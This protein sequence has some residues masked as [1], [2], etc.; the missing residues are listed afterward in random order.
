M[1]DI[2]HDKTLAALEQL[3]AEKT[4]RL[5]DKIAAGDVVSQTVTV[6]CTRDED[7]E[8]ACERALA[9]LPTLDSD[10]RPIHHDLSV[11]V[12]GV[13]R[14]PD[15]ARWV[16]LQT[17]ASSEGPAL[18]SEETAGSGEVSSPSSPSQPSYVKITV[19]NGSEDDPGQIAE[20]YYT[21]EDGQL[22]LRD[23]NDKHLTSRAL[24]NGENPATLAK[25]LLREREGQNDFQQPIH[26]PKLGFA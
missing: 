19:R 11:I 4:R 25:I 10:G 18:P 3:E 12:T 9:N 1:A 13:P 24:L 14:D 6:V 21:I 23:S 26:Y 7:V 17:T 15:F 22:I 20:A 8:E 16:P 2:D 5:Q